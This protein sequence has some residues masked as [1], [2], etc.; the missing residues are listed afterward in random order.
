MPKSKTKTLEQHTARRLRE[1]YGLK[2]TQ[3]LFDSIL[4]Q[5]H[6]NKAKFVLRQSLRV[7][8]WDVVYNVRQQDIENGSLA[9]PGEQ[10]IRVAYDK[11]RK[12]IITVLSLD[13]DP[14]A[15]GIE[16]D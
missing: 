10:T 14:N 9:V 13:M 12:T 5:I 2:Y 4:H 11:M 3:M 7:T 8:L 1:R 15:I 16:C 6:K